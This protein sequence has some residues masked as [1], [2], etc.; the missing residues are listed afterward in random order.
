MG[1]SPDEVDLFFFNRPNPSSRTMAQ[2]VGH[3]ES[4]CTNKRDPPGLSNLKK[5]AKMVI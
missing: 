5:T 3:D 1:S 4:M 2:A